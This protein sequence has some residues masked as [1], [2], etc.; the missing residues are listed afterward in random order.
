MAA[1]T[2]NRISAF[3]SGFGIT[4]L[5]QSST[6][7]AL[8]LAT[9]CEGGLV[10]LSAGIAMILGADIAT[11]LLSLVFSFDIKW[12]APL[13]ICL[14]FIVHRIYFKSGR[15]RH[16]GVLILSLGLIL[17]ALSWIRQSAAPLGESNI[18]PGILKVLE[19]DPLMALIIG[20]F[21]TWMVHSS[22]AVILL[23]AS[24]AAAGLI[25]PILGIFMVLGA[26]LGG[27]M[28][29]FAA[30]LREKPEARRIPA[31]NFI[32]RLMGAVVIL[33]F[34]GGFGNDAFAI[35]SGIYPWIGVGSF[36]IGVHIA[37]NLVLAFVALFFTSALARL[38][39]RI[40]PDETAIDNDPKKPLYL[41][42][43]QIDTPGLAIT[44]AMRETQRMA[45]IVQSML[46]DTIGALGNNDERLVEAVHRKDDIVD[47]LYTEIK[48]YLARLSEESLDSEES[49]QYMRI[50][51]YC[52]NLEAAGDIIDK[53]LIDMAQ[54]K[55]RM[56]KFFSKNG[57]EDINEI[58]NFVNQTMESAHSV[59][60]NEN[61]ELAREMMQRKGEIRKAEN[62][63]TE[64]HLV[65]IREGVPESIG[66]SSIHLDIIRDYRRINSHISTLA[67][68][69]LEGS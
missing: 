31:A 12:L 44:S 53:S 54:K 58:H 1:R 47:S 14:G 35:L 24:F 45:D 65:R 68:P 69:V 28:V 25:A 3:F 52:I 11:S 51:S 5:L 60:L 9:L 18:L 19:G 40:I 30:T 34:A 62:K 41:D 49:R 10:S 59:F 42:I 61:L 64:A 15:R 39:L 27:A 57:W 32:L 2:R 6:A 46:S 38:L 23:L 22:L 8:L 50:M 67:Y 43:K 36:I 33:P 13:F 56:H 4:A 17:L 20:F 55:I 26:N 63:A 48:H 16:L 29:P 37:F 21:L 7:T 66:T